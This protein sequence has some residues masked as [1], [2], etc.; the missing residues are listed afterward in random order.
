[1]SQLQVSSTVPLQN[2]EGTQLLLLLS[3]GSKEQ[4]TRGGSVGPLGLAPNPPRSRTQER[5]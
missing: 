4:K 2:F 3:I 5:D 1:M